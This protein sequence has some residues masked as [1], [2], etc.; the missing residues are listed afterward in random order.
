MHRVHDAPA[1]VD[2]LPKEIIGRLNA[3]V[4]RM[5]KRC[6]IREGLQAYLDDNCHTW[7][8]NAEGAYERFKP[9]RGRRR[10]AQEELLFTL[11]TPS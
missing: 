6:V 1:G 11:A 10:S 3:E 2:A 5:L 8:M 9:R 7:M 4:N